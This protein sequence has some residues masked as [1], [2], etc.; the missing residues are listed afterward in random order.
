LKKSV[1]GGQSWKKLDKPYFKLLTVDS[2][3]TLYAAEPAAE[4]T[5]NRLWKSTDG[6]ASWKEA[7]AGLP[8]DGCHYVSKLS[9]HPQEPSTLYAGIA[10]WVES[11]C[12]AVEPAVVWRSTDGG[13]SWEPFATL[14]EVPPLWLGDWGSLVIHRQNPDIMCASTA[15]GLFKSSDGGASWSTLASAAFR[16]GGGEGPV[17]GKVALDW[18]NP[19]TLFVVTPLAGLFKSTDGGTTWK[20]LTN[21]LP[22]AEAVSTVLIDPH[23]SSTLY[24]GTGFGVF[25]ST[26]GGESWEAV[27]TGLTSLP[28]RVLAIDPVNSNRLYAGTAGGI[29]VITLE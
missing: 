18:Q 9:V 15:R 27:N 6:G 13:S 20:P 26:D 29:F 17:T 22:R 16:A 25:R 1:D 7:N 24:A 14:P 19:D 2:A 28:V 3:G 5:P 21:G 12:A 8:L 10:V 4:E 11:D 23:N